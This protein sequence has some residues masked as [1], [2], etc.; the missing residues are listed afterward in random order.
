MPE[1]INNS[2]KD[3]DTDPSLPSGGEGDDEDEDKVI[4]EAIE[5]GEGADKSQQDV[6]LKDKLGE[7][8]GKEFPDDET[9]LKAVKDTFNF[10]GEIGNI[11]ELKSAMG[12]LQKVFN[13][14][15]K[16]VLN[17]V[18]EIVKTGGTGKIDPTKFVA[19]SDFDRSN[20]YLN[21]P[22]YKP[23]TRLVEIY[24][25]ANPDKSREEI[26]EMD[27]FKEDFDKIKAH[28]ETEKSKSVLK[29]SPRLGKMTDKISEAREAADKGDHA[30][31]EQKAVE[32]VT[33]A[34]PVIP[35]EK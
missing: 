23:Y 16:G 24:Q 17:K 8:L 22:D 14:D 29:S 32:A 11:K 3:Q 13:T 20:F 15:Q 4:D 19:K 27:D 21:N 1:E 35:K 10:V 34:Y 9:A 31:A 18:D 26:V 28:D 2:K 5:G 25:K 30:T 7:A 12:Q 6:S 33:E